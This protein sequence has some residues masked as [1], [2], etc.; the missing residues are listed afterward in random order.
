MDIV[1][2]FAFLH[3]DSGLLSVCTLGCVL[4]HESFVSAFLGRLHVE[5]ERCLIF[6]MLGF[7]MYSRVRTHYSIFFSCVHV[8]GFQFRSTHWRL[9]G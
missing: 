7:R 2:F 5:R 8:K 1:S 6:Y 3:L 9:A 4:F